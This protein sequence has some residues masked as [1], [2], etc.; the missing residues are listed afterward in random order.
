V[1]SACASRARRFA[2]GSSLA[3]AKRASSDHARCA[4]RRRL[5]R[6]VHILCGASASCAERSRLR[7]SAHLSC[8]AT[9]S[10]VAWSFLVPRGELSCG[11]ARF[12]C[13]VAISWM[14]HA[15]LVR[16]CHLPCGAVTSCAALTFLMHRSQFLCGADLSRVRRGDLPRRA[17]SADETVRRSILSSG[18]YEGRR[19]L[20]RGGS[21]PC[22]RECPSAA[23]PR[24]R[25]FLP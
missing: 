17:V 13:D 24:R 14:R 12:V 19:S 4:W 23:R 21:A 10:S 22:S 2:G 5:L 1:R 20:V 9:L 18:S 8:G 15:F 16:R 11:A 7:R 6:C 25:E 3:C